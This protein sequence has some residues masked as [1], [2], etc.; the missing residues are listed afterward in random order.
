M[1]GK[2][3]WGVLLLCLALAGGEEA[4]SKDKTILT[5]AGKKLTVQVARSEEE[6][7]RGLM[8]R[9]TLG[10]DEGM[11]FVYESEEPLSFWMKNTRI[12]L[13]IAFLNR[14]GKILE[15]QDMEPFSLASHVSKMPA[16]Y[17]LEVNRGWFQR[18]RVRPGDVVKIPAT[19]VK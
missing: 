10:K 1:R 9:E 13:S 16:K 11:L 4:Q 15:I 14:E 12:P 18:N 7:S 3:I 19:A 17:A 8:F 6:K 2:P 5:V